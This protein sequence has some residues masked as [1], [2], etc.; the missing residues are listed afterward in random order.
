MRSNL[1]NKKNVFL[2]IIFFIIGFILKIVG[3]KLVGGAYSPDRAYSWDRI[4]D[5]LHLTFIFSIIFAFLVF[6]AYLSDKK[7]Q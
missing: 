1:F 4:I 5:E 6:L 3:N 2:F 7:D